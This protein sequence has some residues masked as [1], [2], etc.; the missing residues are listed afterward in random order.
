MLTD[1]RALG[2]KDVLISPSL[3]DIKS[4]K[5]V[6]LERTFTFRNGLQ[7]TFV[8]VIAANMAGIGTLEVAKILSKYKMLTCL[9]KDI[10]LHTYINL[11]YYNFSTFQYTIPT[12]GLAN[13]FKFKIWAGDVPF[14]IVCL[15]VANG[16]MKDFIDFVKDIKH[17]YPN[18]IIIAGNVATFKGAQRLSAAGAD[19]VKVGIG[20]GSVCTTRYKTGVG[21]P[22]VTAINDIKQGAYGY[23]CS[24]GG[25]TGPGDVA[26][27]FVAGADFVMVGGMLAGTK[28]TG[29]EFAGSATDSIGDYKT[30]EGKRVT[31]TKT[32]NL[33]TRVQEIMGG[34][35]STGSYIG[36]RKIEDYYKAELIQCTEQTNNVFGPPC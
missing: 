36:Q 32:I 25:C 5:D 6:S 18:K 33:E 19:I 3:S 8:P 34:L 7:K 30:S 4:R 17:N 35:R 24:D 9:N 22:Q 15:D 29:Q 1:K 13:L 12:F 21:V 11:Y 28:E 27:A 10:E 31:F 23:L 26:K 20:S 2:F 16:Y 14:D